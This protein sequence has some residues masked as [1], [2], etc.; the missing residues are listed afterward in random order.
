MCIA[1]TAPGRD[2]FDSVSR[3][4]APELDIYEDPVTGSTHCMIAPYWAE[5]LGKNVIHAYQ[6]SERSGEL[7]CEV[8]GDTVSIT[9]K[10]VL[11]AISELN[12]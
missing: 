9:G 5:K 12:L 1:V 10:A 7:L 3:V 6:A 8:K 4:F 2:G 11:F